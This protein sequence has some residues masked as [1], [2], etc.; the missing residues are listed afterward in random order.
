[1][2]PRLLSFDEV[3]HFEQVANQL[4]A[5]PWSR[6]HWAIDLMLRPFHSDSLT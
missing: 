3:R 5:A 1:M 6:H 2:R 4:R